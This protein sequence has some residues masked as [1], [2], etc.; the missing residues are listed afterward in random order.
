MTTPTDTDID[1]AILRL[2]GVAKAGQWDNVLSEMAADLGRA[3]TC[4][5]YKRPSSGWTF[6][7]QAAYFGHQH[8]VRA[9]VGLGASL[10]ARTNDGE[11]PGD[12][13]ERR[14]HGDLSRSMVAAAARGGGLWEPSPAP[15]L[16]PSSSAWDEAEQRRALLEMRVAYGESVVVIPPASRYFVDSFERV[17]VGWHG[18][19]DPPGGMDGES[20]VRSSRSS[21]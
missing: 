13:A 20:L 11:T 12:V 4:S 10:L 17:L 7:H 18:T 2:Y 8:A 5:R 15:E 14:G 6:L 21:T 19:F 1:Q 3:K 16:L 9:L